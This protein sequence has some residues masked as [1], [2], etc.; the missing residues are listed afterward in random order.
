MGIRSISFLLGK[1]IYN[2]SPHACTLFER[3]SIYVMPTWDMIRS[4]ALE[5]L[6]SLDGLYTV[7]KPVYSSYS[8]SKRNHYINEVSYPAISAICVGAVVMLF[9]KFIVEE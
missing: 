4:V 9:E 7:I 1:Y 3:D 8:R 6:K 2:V 5:Y